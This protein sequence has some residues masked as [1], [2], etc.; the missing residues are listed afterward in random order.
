MS[1]GGQRKTRLERVAALELPPNFAERFLGSL[2]RGDVWLRIGLCVLATLFLWIVTGAWAPPF[3]Y[4]TGYVP[5]RDILAQVSFKKYDPDATHDARKQAENQVRFVYTQ[6]PSSLV[7]LRAAL[8]NKLLEISN[9][10]TLDALKSDVWKE[11]TPPPTPNVDPPTKEEEAEDYRQFHDWIADK[12]KQ[13]KIA[14]AID[15]AFAPLEQNGVID[16]LTQGHDEGNQT[17]IYVHPAGTTLFP[18]VVQVPDV[19]MGEA[20]S[21]LHDRLREQLN[22]PDIAQRLFYWI[23]PKV[24]PTL[25]LDVDATKAAQED[26]AKKVQ[27]QYKEYLK[28]KDV[29]VKADDTVTEDKI[30]L[31]R[32]E[33]DA[34]VN[35][36]TTTDEIARSLAFFGM[37]L[38]MFTLSGFYILFREPSIFRNLGRFSAMLG[39]FVVAVTLVAM[40]K[41][42]WRVD[43]IPV[44]LFGMTVALVYNQELALLLTAALVLVV[45]V[46]VLNEDLSSYITLMSAAVASILLLGKIRS[47]SKLIYVG[48]AA[49][50]IAMLTEIGDS[51]LAGQPLKQ[52]LVFDV[53]PAGW[54]AVA[55]GFLMT[56]LL[57]FIEKS[58]GV[59]TDI[60]LLEIGD[61]SHPL[62]QELVRRAPGTYNHSIN[63][64]A[65]GEAAAD[66]IG[67]RGLLVRVGAY[68]HDIG[69]MLK[70][71]YFAENQVQGSPS[72][73]ETL[74]PAMSRLIIVAHVKDG[75]DLARQHHLP[76]RVIDFIE[77]HHGT[78]LVEYFFRR[79]AQQSESDPSRGEVEEHSYR[80]PGPKPQTREAGVLMLADAA[81]SAS[82]TLVDPAPARLESLVHDLAMSRLLDGQFD[83]CGLTLQELHDVEESLVKSL[84]AVYHGRVR[85]PEQ[86]TA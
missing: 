12:D 51:I 49:A 38:A 60:S 81:E 75:A 11:F 41:D 66:A 58:F 79:A 73:H 8:K 3:S 61:V 56:G 69:K 85:Y 46:V 84:T 82:R 37:M 43:S 13:E 29:L 20:A 64:A 5:D 16:K 19:L 59:L 47:R 78:T 6:D 17:E 26:A 18:Q 48:L 77:Q 74:L 70:P 28:G 52:T 42:A 2:Q 22:S 34:Y 80:Y 32:L 72:L 35:T 68:F 1:L 57:P 31:L 55:A 71:Q 30:A 63:V 45:S 53:P 50:V 40:A 36:L 27:D 54:G 10:A 24:T 62:L 76:Q 4:R 9:A 83:D 23:K 33:H 44:M 25:K 65:I 21:K 7:Q 67:A 15:S 39:M 86:R 14:K